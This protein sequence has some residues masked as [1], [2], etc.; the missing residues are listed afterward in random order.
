MRPDTALR[1]LIFESANQTKAIVLKTTTEK[2]N[3]NKSTIK[4]VRLLM[5]TC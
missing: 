2:D 5:Q 4:T 3:K 1:R